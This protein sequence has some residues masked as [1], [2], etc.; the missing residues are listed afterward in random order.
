MLFR[1]VGNPDFFKKEDI[2]SLLGDTQLEIR[3]ILKGVSD[4]EFMENVIITDFMVIPYRKN[5]NGNSGPLTEAIV[6]NIP[7]IVADHG[8]LGNL[9]KKYKFG[10]TFESENEE[11]LRNII[12]KTINENIQYDFSYREKLNTTHFIDS[13]KQL[14]LNLIKKSSNL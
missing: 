7:S 11:S 4:Q 5:F 14:Y 6:N 12:F 8:N 1:S 10:I 3:M 2:L 13:H 9:T